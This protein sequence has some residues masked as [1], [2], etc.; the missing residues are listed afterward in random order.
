MKSKKGIII[1]NIVALIIIICTLL[2]KNNYVSYQKSLKI[3]NDVLTESYERLIDYSIYSNNIESYFEGRRFKEDARVFHE[4]DTL[5]L[6]NILSDGKSLLIF[7]S[8][9]ECAPCSDKITN[10]VLI[11]LDTIESE[12]NIKIITDFPS[13]RDYYVFQQSNPDLKHDVFNS[14]KDSSFSF[15]S[16]AVVLI[17]NDQVITGLFPIDANYIYFFHECVPGIVE[18]IESDLQEKNDFRGKI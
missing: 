9:E 18:Y 2:I 4:G 13:V 3:A 10:D 12:A 17:G 7:L 14:I 5:L 15:S 1:A 6:R 16:S 11:M 8:S